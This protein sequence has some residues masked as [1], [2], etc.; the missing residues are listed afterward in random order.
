MHVPK[1]GNEEFAAGV[2]DVGGL[3]ELGSPGGTDRGD[4]I[5]DNDDG[6]IRQWSAASSVDDTDMLQD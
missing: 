3:I 6:L 5:S 1:A 2:D 4:S